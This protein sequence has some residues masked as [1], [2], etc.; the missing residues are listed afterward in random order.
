MYLP[1]DAILNLAKAIFYFASQ[2]KDKRER[3]KDAEL[4]RLLQD[5]L[6]DKV[7]DKI[8]NIMRRASMANREAL[9]RFHNLGGVKKEE[10]T[11]PASEKSNS[12]ERENSEDESDEER[13]R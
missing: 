4:A 13:E 7:S 5:T 9:N 6:K 1:L 10:K 11:K 3:A 12:S 8:I 2:W